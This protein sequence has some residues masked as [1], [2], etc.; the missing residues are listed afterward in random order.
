MGAPLARPSRGAGHAVHGIGRAIARSS[1]ARGNRLPASNLPSIRAAGWCGPHTRGHP[2]MQSMEPGES[3]RWCYVRSGGDVV[4]GAGP[5]SRHR[6]PLYRGHTFIQAGTD[7]RS[8]SDC[9]LPHRIT[10]RRPSEVVGQVVK[11][12]DT[13]KGSRPLRVFVDPADDGAEDVFRMA[14]G[15]AS[16]STSGSR[17][18]IWSA[19]AVQRHRN[20]LASDHLH[21]H[22]IAVHYDDPDVVS[23]GNNRRVRPPRPHRPTG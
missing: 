4:G 20:R 8:T 16:G 6:V 3:W 19:L 18:R 21:E 12:A 2:F 14:T 23:I 17:C 13:L 22:A 10:R 1:T 15:C 5:G 7:R 11:V 9:S